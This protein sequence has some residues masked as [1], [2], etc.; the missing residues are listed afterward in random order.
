MDGIAQVDIRQQ[1]VRISDLAP[2]FLALDNHIGITECREPEALLQ[3]QFGLVHFMQAPHKAFG[4]I[5]LIE[6]NDGGIHIDGNAIGARLVE[7]FAR[8]KTQLSREASLGITQA[9]SSVIVDK[10]HILRCLMDIVFNT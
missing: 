5:D 7:C 3:A 8:G 4:H 10:R 6:G 1:Q 9:R 2:H